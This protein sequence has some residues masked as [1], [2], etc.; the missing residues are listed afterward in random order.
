MQLC[1]GNVFHC[2]AD[3][4]VKRNTAITFGKNN[5]TSRTHINGKLFNK[6]LFNW[7]YDN[8]IQFQQMYIIAEIKQ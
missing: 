8:R 3:A 4:V 1:Q 6:E 2:L 5:V 7:T